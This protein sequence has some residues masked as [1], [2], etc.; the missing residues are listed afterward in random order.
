MLKWCRVNASLTMAAVVVFSSCAH[1][2]LAA[3]DPGS[4]ARI[5]QRWCAAC[6]V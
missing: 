1:D 2:A 6:H 3:G 5:A 4:G